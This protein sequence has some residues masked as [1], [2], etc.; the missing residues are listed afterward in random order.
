MGLDVC[1]G[2]DSLGG[3][4]TD[5][6]L[7]KLANI[8][9]NFPFLDGSGTC[10]GWAGGA[11]AGFAG[12]RDTDFFLKVFFN[13]L[14]NILNFPGAFA[15]GACGGGA[16][17]CGACAGGACACGGG[18]CACGACA[19]GACACGACACGACAC[20]ACACAGFVGGFL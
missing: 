16:C 18:A 10:A 4:A 17:A 5:F 11:C 9:L 14:V 1:N 15:C 2:T 6:F 8:F 20:G 13:K 12:G 7:N 3:G 19:C